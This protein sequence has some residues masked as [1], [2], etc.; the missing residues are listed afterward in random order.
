MEV[1]ITAMAFPGQCKNHR[2]MGKFMVDRASR[3]LQPK[4]LLKIGSATLN[5]VD[6]DLNLSSM[7]I[8]LE[9]SWVICSNA[10]LCSWGKSFSLYPASISLYYYFFHFMCIIIC[11]PCTAVK[12]LAP[13][14]GGPSSRDGSCTQVPS[15]LSLVQLNQ[16]SSLSPFLQSKCSCP[17]PLGGPQ[18]NSLQ[19]IDAF[20]VTFCLPKMIAL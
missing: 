16:P 8:V 6:W 2:T 3:G 18:M 4:L 9:Q 11:P 12:S 10:Q 17:E 1:K 15:G 5:E 13:F 14:V 19:L 20:H 7:E